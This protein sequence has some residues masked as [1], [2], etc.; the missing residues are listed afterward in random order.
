M[1]ETVKWSIEESLVYR[2]AL[3][4]VVNKPPGIS[5]HVDSR[6]GASLE[7]HFPALQFG[8]PNPPVLAHR[9]DKD[10]SGCLILARNKEGARRMTQLFKEGSVQKVYHAVVHGTPFP[11]EGTIS[12]PMAKLDDRSYTCRMKVDAAGKEAVTEYR[13]LRTFADDKALLE[14]TPKT[15]RTHQLRVHCSAIG[16]PVVGDTI[17]GKE[18]YGSSPPLHLHALSVCVP[19]YPKRAAPLQVSAPPPAFWE[20]FT[21]KDGALR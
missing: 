18:K 1:K 10:T 3:I 15:G 5:V 7:D 2:D 4:L 11:L 8:L 20:P 6:G 9:L 19:L 17:Y 21:G 13:V 14:L 16:H 12:K